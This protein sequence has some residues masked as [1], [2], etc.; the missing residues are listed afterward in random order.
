MSRS[1]TNRTGA[2]KSIITARSSNVKREHRKEVLTMTTNENDIRAI[3]ETMSEDQLRDILALIRAI[4]AAPEC[5]T[6]ERNAQP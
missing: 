1:Y 6:N 3:L 4:A 5:S 2:G